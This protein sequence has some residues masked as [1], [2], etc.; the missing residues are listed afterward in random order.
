[1]HWMVTGAKDGSLAA[2]DVRKYGPN[3]WA[4]LKRFCTPLSLSVGEGD[5]VVAVE[6]SPAN[7]IIA[8]YASGTIPAHCFPM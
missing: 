3:P 4:R 1:M 7:V 2:F 5:P 6:W 8:A